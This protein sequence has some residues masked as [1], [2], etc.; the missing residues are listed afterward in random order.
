MS[1]AF[2]NKQAKY[3][4]PAIALQTSIDRGLAAQAKYLEIYED[5]ILNPALQNILKETAKRM[6]VGTT[7]TPNPTVQPSCTPRP[8][9]LD[10]KPRCLIPEPAESWCP[11]SSPST[12][13]PRICTQDAKKCPDGS[14]VSRTGPNCEFAPC[15][16]Q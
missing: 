7:T 8:A 10:S 12:S 1:A 14:Y 6:S 9:C 4:D 11:A 13:S 3:G 15:P 5:D 2:T 16:G